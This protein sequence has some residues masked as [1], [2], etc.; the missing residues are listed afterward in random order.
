M[1]KWELKEATAHQQIS[2]KEKKKAEKTPES[3][4]YFSSSLFFKAANGQLTG[5]RETI[6]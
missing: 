2:R 5:N 6:N 3:P 4:A 1:Q